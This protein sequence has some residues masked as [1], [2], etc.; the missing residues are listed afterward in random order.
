MLKSRPLIY[1]LVEDFDEPLTPSH[2]LHARRLLSLPDV[3]ISSLVKVKADK[4]IVTRRMKYLSTLLLHYWNQWRWHYLL[5]LRECHKLVWKKK[6][7]KFEISIGDIVIVYEE[8]QLR[9]N[10]RLGKIEKVIRRK[11]GHIRGALL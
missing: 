9:S 3:P 7:R 4:S 2:L 10:W 5:D 11:D 1:Y 8:K 6:G